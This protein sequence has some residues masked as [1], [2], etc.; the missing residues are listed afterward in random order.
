VIVRGGELQGESLRDQVGEQR[1]LA[2]VSKQ[3][4]VIP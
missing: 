3:V 4:R 1:V 2:L